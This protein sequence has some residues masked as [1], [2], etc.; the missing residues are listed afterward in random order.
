MA[1]TTASLEASLASLGVPLPEICNAHG[2]PGDW[3]RD[4]VARIA[5]GAWIMRF[6]DRGMVQAQASRLATGEEDVAGLA[7]VAEAMGIAPQGGGP[8]FLGLGGAGGGKAGKPAASA[9]S[10]AAKGAKGVA[11]A[12]TGEHATA[13]VVGDGLDMLR[14]AIDLAREATEWEAAGGWQVMEQRRAGE[15]AV[16]TEVARVASLSQ[17]QDGAGLFAVGTA[18]LLPQMPPVVVSALGGGKAEGP[19][20]GGKVWAA[21]LDEELAAVADVN[22]E[23]GLR[24][25]EARRMGD[26]V[27]Y[28]GT[29]ADVMG[30]ARD[31]ETRRLE[32]ALARMDT[33]V[34]KVNHAPFIHA[35]SLHSI[36]EPQR[37]HLQPTSLISFS[38]GFHASFSFLPPPD[39][40]TGRLTSLRVAS[41]WACMST[42]GPPCG[43][44]RGRASIPTSATLRL[45]CTSRRAGRRGFSRPSG[46][47]GDEPRNAHASFHALADGAVPAQAC[48]RRA[49]RSVFGV[50]WGGGRL[51][52]GRRA[53]PR[54]THRHRAQEHRPG[55]ALI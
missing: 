4:P 43:A 8:A 29:E 52:S 50:E 23:R 25:E 6:I 5:V 49:H 12:T 21:W 11:A 27:P 24:L 15:R 7:R 19:A 35:G 20:R 40:A 31:V 54:R 44:H 16:I 1:S 26:G 34:E 42:S 32:A 13:A 9:A 41:S 38:Q 55:G 37:A 18:G 45:P 53:A 3:T 33:S 30:G 39:F 22:A 14:L 36:A 17:G 48:E 28:D 51:L 46:I 2:V 47:S 10:R